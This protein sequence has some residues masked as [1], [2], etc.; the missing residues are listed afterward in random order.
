MF[1]LDV[2]AQRYYQAAGM[3]WSP[4]GRGEPGGIPKGEHVDASG[5]PYKNVG[6]GNYVYRVDPSGRV[7]RR[8]K[9]PG[10]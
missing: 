9:K 5:Q 7:I 10:R 3:N 1:G 2:D 4:P 8:Y 6:V